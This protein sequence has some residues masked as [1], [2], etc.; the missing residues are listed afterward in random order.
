MREDLN[1]GACLTP[2]AGR[3]SQDH[4]VLTNSAGGSWD[5]LSESLFWNFLYFR[6]VDSLFPKTKI[7]GAA[8]AL[9][10][11]PT[12]EPVGGD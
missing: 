9:T 12:W 2:T 10:Q 11:P 4:E 1:T 7:Y 8:A 6:R 5:A 3:G